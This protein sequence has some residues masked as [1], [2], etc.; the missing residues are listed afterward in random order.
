MMMPGVQN[1]RLAFSY[2]IPDKKMG[3]PRKAPPKWIIKGKQVYEF[4]CLSQF[5]L[6]F[7]NVGFV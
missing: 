6:D 4:T 1:V 7:I 3:M 2:G 5:S